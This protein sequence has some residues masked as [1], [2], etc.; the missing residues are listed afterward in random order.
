MNKYPTVIKHEH[1]QGKSLVF[2]YVIMTLCNSGI[3]LALFGKVSSTASSIKFHFKE[4]N[5]SRFTRCPLITHPPLTLTP[6]D[7]RLLLFLFFYFGLTISPVLST[8]CFLTR[9]KMFITIINAWTPFSYG[10]L[11]YVKLIRNLLFWIPQF[12]W[13]LIKAYFPDTR[14]VFPVPWPQYLPNTRFISL[15]ICKLSW[16]QKKWNID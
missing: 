9:C 4:H 13:N 12:E 11:Q 10:F 7:T 8:F 15:V 2:F 16:L 14:T 1:K 6:A 5:P 3:M